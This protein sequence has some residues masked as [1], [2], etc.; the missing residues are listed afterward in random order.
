ME[1]EAAMYE[2]NGADVAVTLERD[3]VDHALVSL[4]V[5]REPAPGWGYYETVELVDVDGDGDGVDA[6]L[7]SH[8]DEVLEHYG[9]SLS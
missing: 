8:E 7:A 4:R 3:G 5:L 9:W 6:W 1:L 2:W